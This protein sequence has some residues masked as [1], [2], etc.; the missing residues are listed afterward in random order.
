MAI[1]NDHYKLVLSAT[2]DYDANTDGCTTPTVTGF[3]AIDEHVPPKID[4]EDTNLL[5][6]PNLLNA[7]KKR[8][9]T[10]LSAKLE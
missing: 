9:F 7:R 10:R 3:Y 8:A 2:T 4:N 1:R 5:A 6:A